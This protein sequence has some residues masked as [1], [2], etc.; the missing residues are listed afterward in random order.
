MGAAPMGW[1]NQPAFE[2]DKLIALV[3]IEALRLK[4]DPVLICAICEQESGWDPWAMRYEPGFFSKYVAGLY[5]TGKITATEAYARAFSYGLMQVMGQ[6]A[7]E[8][9][10]DGKYLI[11]LCDP[12]TAAGVGCWVFNEKLKKA[13][14]D[15]N[16]A[17]LAWN[18]GANKAYPMEVIARMERYKTNVPTTT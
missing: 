9:G 15:I 4:L 17:L 6:V 5:S 11:E 18:G 7:R 12:Q 14:G 1:F 8:A 3:T 10:F 2:K 16:K 13:G